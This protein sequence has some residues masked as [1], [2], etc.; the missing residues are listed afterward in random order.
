MFQAFKL[1]YR[2]SI[3]LPSSHLPPPLPC[4]LQPS[5]LQPSSLPLLHP[6]QTSIT[7]EQNKQINYNNVAV[8]FDIKAPAARMRLMRLKIALDG[9]NALQKR[10]GTGNVPNYP[11]IG[12]GTG[13][14]GGGIG[15]GGKGVYGKGGG[16]DDDDDEDQEWRVQPGW[17][18]IKNEEDDD[19]ALAVRRSS[20]KGRRRGTR[21]GD[22]E[23]GDRKRRREEGG[24][25]SGGIRFQTED[26]FG[27]GAGVKMEEGDVKTEDG[28]QRPSQSPLFKTEV[29]GDAV[30]FKTEDVF[31]E[32]RGLEEVDVGVKL[33]E[34][35]RDSPVLFKTE[36]LFGITEV[37]GT[38]D[39]P[40]TPTS[41]ALQAVNSTPVQSVARHVCTTPTS[42]KT[43]EMD[44]TP[45]SSVGS[46]YSTPAFRTNEKYQTPLSIKTDGPDDSFMTGPKTKNDT[47]MAIK[48]E[49]MHDAETMQS[50]PHHFRARDIFATPMSGKIEEMVVSQV[51]LNEAFKS[52]TRETSVTKDMYRTPMSVK[53]ETRESFA[54][55]REQTPRSA[56]DDDPSGRCMSLK[57]EVLQEGESGEN[58]KELKNEG[59]Q[60]TGMEEG[61][62]R[63]LVASG[64]VEFPATFSFGP[65]ASAVEIFPVH[66]NMDN[67]DESKAWATMPSFVSTDMKQEDNMI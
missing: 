32:A 65:A 48:M 27:S 52:A 3:H 4:F 37:P 29:F 2:K 63:D 45:I 25:G 67:E 53:T 28:M 61:D 57:E 66:Q 64:V 49:N 39:T 24:S 38:G 20:A 8:D 46:M 21:G 35:M 12:K 54:T 7:K 18:S 44:T 15:K 34:D 16:G 31:G 50:T 23:G 56:N 13:I 62:G 47:P 22:E 9:Q 26:L 19:K 40:Q 51:P 36:H 42:V 41:N 58:A 11:S 33:E 14:S 55:M 60:D 17:I 30:R 10:F 6:T 5:F 1:R 59:L 43:E